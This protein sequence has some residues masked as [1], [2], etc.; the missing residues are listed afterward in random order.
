MLELFVFVTVWLGL[1]LCA[2]LVAG[3]KGRNRWIWTAVALFV[4]MIGFLITLCLSSKRGDGRPRR[5]CPHCG[6]MALTIAKVCPHC[7]GQLTP[8]VDDIDASVIDFRFA[9]KSYRIDPASPDGRRAPA[10]PE[11]PSPR[12]RAAG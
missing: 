3:N 10:A 8:R 1:T 7:K 4:P 11:A 5:A 9:P 12:R 2:N 6:E